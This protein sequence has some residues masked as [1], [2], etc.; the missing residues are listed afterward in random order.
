M[1]RSIK[2]IQDSF[3]E[4]KKKYKELDVLNSTSKVSIWRLLMY[5][6]SV[7]T[8]TLEKLFDEHKK[9]VQDILV[10]QKAGTPIWYRE[11]VFK[12]QNGFTFN[13]NTGV[14][15]NVKSDGTTATDTEI[16]DSKIIKY[17]SINYVSPSLYIKVAKEDVNNDLA[18]LSDDEVKGLTS[19][20]EKIK[21]AGTKFSIVSKNGAELYI[22]M[23]IY[24][25]SSIIDN[26]GVSISTGKTIVK[27]SIQSYLKNL[28]FDGYFVTNDLIAH[29][30]GM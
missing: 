13:E 30:R 3:I 1:A 21:F 17:S 22:T 23:T 20:I 11:Q 9:E 4:E 8:N 26:N 15:S 12:Y 19:Y 28:K 29:L 10:K 6:V 18:K 25:D 7:G 24:K 16:A 5:V 2:T 14:F 27:D